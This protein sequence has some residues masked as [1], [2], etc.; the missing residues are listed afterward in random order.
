M[1]VIYFSVQST[2][3]NPDSCVTAPSNLL[4][5]PQKCSGLLLVLPYQINIRT[6]KKYLEW[7][8]QRGEQL[9]M[10]HKY[11]SWAVS[12]VQSSNGN[13]QDPQN[14]GQDQVRAVWSCQC[15]A[16]GWKEHVTNL[17]KVLSLLKSVS[18]PLENWH[19]SAQWKAFVRPLEGQYL[20]RAKGAV[21]QNDDSC[22]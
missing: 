8:D 18:S 21:R 14:K 12:S 22:V 16:G 9:R 1:E 17:S 6:F 15:P 5:H 3:N 20:L 4:I 2:G 13:N 19:G 10:K 11:K 7:E